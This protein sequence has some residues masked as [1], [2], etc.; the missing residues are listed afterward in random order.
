MKKKQLITNLEEYLQM[1]GFDVSVTLDNKLVAEGD[2][3]KIHISIEDLVGD[4]EE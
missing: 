4:K 3:L 1:L 2:R